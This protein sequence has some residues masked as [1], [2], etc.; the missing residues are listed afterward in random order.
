[1][2]QKYGSERLFSKYDNGIYT[3]PLVDTFRMYLCA[4]TD[5]F[6]QNVSIPIQIQHYKM[7][8]CADTDTFPDTF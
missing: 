8:L 3:R 6:L 2:L 4:D 1:M 5:T 7:Y